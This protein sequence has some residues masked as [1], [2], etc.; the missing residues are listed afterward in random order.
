MLIYQHTQQQHFL[1]LPHHFE[2]VGT[3][4]PLNINR[5]W[6]H[7]WYNGHINGTMDT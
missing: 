7:E 1:S 6:T 5:K 4:R 3:I 2:N